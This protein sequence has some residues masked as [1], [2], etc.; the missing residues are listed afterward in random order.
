MAIISDGDSKSG[1]DA[2]WQLSSDGFEIA[3]LSSSNAG[4]TLAR[5]LNGISVSGAKRSASSVR[6]LVDLALDRWGRVDALINSADCRPAA[7]VGV[8]SERH[9]HSIM[10]TYLMNIVRPTRVLAPVMSD[11]GGGT[12][13]NIVNL[14]EV[15]ATILAPALDV[16]R[17]AMVNF[18]NLVDQRYGAA[19]IKM[20]N[21]I[22]DAVV[23]QPEGEECGG[24]M[25][26]WRYRRD[27]EISP[28]VTC[29]VTDPTH[30][31]SDKSVFDGRL[32]SP[33]SVAA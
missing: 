33:Y 10:D 18:F 1:R 24:S 14:D 22:S 2:A 23:G 29:L 20:A 28:L 11:L 21:V 8:D 9:L 6:N 4:E 15:N 32:G 27:E 7:S 19:D 17:N 3:V 5:D 12:I 13:V 26:I 25:P 30:S 16:F 31:V